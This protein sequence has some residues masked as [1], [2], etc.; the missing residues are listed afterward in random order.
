MQLINYEEA[1]HLVMHGEKDGIYVMVPRRMGGMTMEEVR[2]LARD[3]VLF[4]MS[5]V[6]EKEPSVPEKEPVVPEKE[7][8][9]APE[10]E[11][12]SG[13][14]LPPAPEPGDGSKP[15]GRRIDTGKIL[16]LRKAG[17]AVKDIAEDMGLSTATVSSAIWREKKKSE[18][19][20][21]KQNEII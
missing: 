1:V 2:K 20:E 19:K 21:D 10:P 3:G 5:D 4:G 17:W 15:A 8:K 14:L 9:P 13:P 12:G 6:P 11:L 18:S 7:P 16:A